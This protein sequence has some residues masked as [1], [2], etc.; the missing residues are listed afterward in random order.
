MT[1]TRKSSPKF[2]FL[3][4]DFSRSRDSVAVTLC[5][6]MAKAEKARNT[7][8]VLSR[9]FTITTDY[10]AAFLLLDRGFTTCEECIKEPVDDEDLAAEHLVQIAVE[11]DQLKLNQAVCFDFR[12]TR[13]YLET[14]LIAEN[15]SPAPSF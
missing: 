3:L 15:A 11:I 13:R 12:S 8:G 5:S 9:I 14:R 4:V 6:T 1:A 2:V 10:E 7:I